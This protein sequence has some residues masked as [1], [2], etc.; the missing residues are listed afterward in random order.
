MHLYGIFVG[1]AGTGLRLTDSVK[2]VASSVLK[3]E[4]TFTEELVFV[5]FGGYNKISKL[6]PYLQR[7]LGKIDD[8]QIGRIL[9]LVKG[10]KHTNQ[11]L[12]KYM[13]GRYRYTSHFLSL[14]L[15]EQTNKL[16]MSK[17]GIIERALVVSQKLK[18]QLNLKI[19]ISKCNKSQQQRGWIQPVLALY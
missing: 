13:L 2:F 1:V 19:S 9:N 15:T 16:T 12:I 7:Y 4:S 3:S 17:E 5:D 18:L 8:G 11:I 6:R 14:V 10:T